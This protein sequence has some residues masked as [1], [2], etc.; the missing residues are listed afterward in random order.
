MT[1]YS[2]LDG[3]DAHAEPGHP[4]R[5]AR[6]DAIR[7]RIEGDSALDALVRIFGPPASREALERVH[8]PAYLDRLDAFCAA[9]EARLAA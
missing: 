7:R 3:D 1:V 4:D 6:L 2:L 5:P 8:P 9:G